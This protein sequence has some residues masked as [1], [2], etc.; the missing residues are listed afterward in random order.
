MLYTTP[1]ELFDAVVDSKNRGDVE[2]HLDCYESNATIVL[3][4]GS[5]A[6]GHDALRGFLSFFTSLKPSFRV[7]RREFIEGPET[8]L[9]LSEW[10]LTG[11]DSEG[12]P[13]T[14]AVAQATFYANKRT[15]AGS[16]HSTTPGAPPCLISLL[17][18]LG[19]KPCLPITNNG[20]SIC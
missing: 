5:V 18:P 3:Q 13:S 20:L 2:A 16:S 4:P 12:N 15:A 8:T 11:V 14:G 10:T 19:E 6:S 1:A 17:E 7:T 9:H